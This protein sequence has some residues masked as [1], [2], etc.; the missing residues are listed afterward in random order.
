M[1]DEEVAIPRH[2]DASQKLEE[3]M[4]M[5]M[6]LSIRVKVIEDQQMEVGA[7]PTCNPST[8]HLV[9]KWARCQLSPDQ[10]GDLSEEMRQRLA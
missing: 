5:L 4:K 7:S 2:A 1:S 8:C 6:D 3:I 10:E 9:R